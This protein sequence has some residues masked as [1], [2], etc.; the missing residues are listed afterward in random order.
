MLT[1]AEIKSL[2]PEI[3]ATGDGTKQT[4]SQNGSTTYTDRG[5]LSQGKWWV[6]GEQYCSSWPPTNFSACYDV[7]IEDTGN[8]ETLLIWIDQSGG[9][10]INRF[11]EAK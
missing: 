10:T 2:L 3:I 7:S 6:S 5:N 9:Q 8:G 1:G 4:F 11:S